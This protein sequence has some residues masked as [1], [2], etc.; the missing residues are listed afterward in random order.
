MTK[1]ILQGAVAVAFVIASMSANAWWMPTA[2]QQAAYTE[3]HQQFVKQQQ[4]LA[5]L[6]WQDPR[7][8]AEQQAELAHQWHQQHLENLQTFHQ[9]AMDMPAPPA[10]LQEA[11]M[12]TERTAPISRE[13]F[14]QQVEEQ[15]A[16]IEAYKETLRQ[17]MEAQRKAVEAQR[18]AV[19]TTL[20][21]HGVPG[22]I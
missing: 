11:P 20:P 17:Q 6:S 13:E 1:S 22:D 4:E 7:A 14:R 8:Y 10:F 12:Q 2:E 9:D 21:D 18:I 19:R 15:R 3:Q 16:A 5:N